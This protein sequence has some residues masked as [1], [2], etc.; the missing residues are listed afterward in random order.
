[1]APY[2]IKYVDG[3]DRPWKIVRISD[4]KIVGSSKSKKKAAASI[5]ARMSGESKK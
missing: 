4:R 2:S 5:R 3:D 1:M